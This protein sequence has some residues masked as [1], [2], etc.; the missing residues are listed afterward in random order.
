MTTT[1]QQVEQIQA[2]CE[3]Y[4]A[5]HRAYEAAD[6]AW[7]RLSGEDFKTA[8][9]RLNA[10]RVAAGRD[11]RE[12]CKLNGLTQTC[13]MAD[14]SGVLTTCEAYASKALGHVAIWSGFATF[15]P[16]SEVRA[17]AKA[18]AIRARVARDSAQY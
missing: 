7:G 9:G 4:T 10:I 5:A 2:A 16:A 3:N 8:R 14:G 12:V 17:K 13:S 15:T 11:L 1:Q 6:Y 18:N